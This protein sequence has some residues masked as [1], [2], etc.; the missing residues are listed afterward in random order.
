MAGDIL[1]LIVAVTEG[2][3]AVNEDALGY[4]G[5]AE[6]VSAVWVFDGVTRINNRNLLPAGGDAQWLVNKASNHL[7]N[8]AGQNAPLPQMLSDVVRILIADWD[9]PSAKL[10]LRVDFDPPAACLI[11]AKRHAD[12]GAH[13]ILVPH[14]PTRRW[15]FT[16]V[17]D[18]SQQWFDRLLAEEAK[19]RHAHG[20]FHVKK[21]LANSD[22]AFWQ[23]GKPHKP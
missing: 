10:G 2:S 6:D 19:L 14:L 4:L 18:F 20:K 13:F 11:L 1:K 23:T 15:T 3:S 21:L 9:E 12:G 16:K 5:Q 17:D 7:Q 8:L 22:R